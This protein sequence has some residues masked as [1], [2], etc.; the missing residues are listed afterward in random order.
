MSAK[1]KKG[2]SGSKAVRKLLDKK[3]TVSP[4][5]TTKVPPMGQTGRTEKQ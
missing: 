4:G 1:L 5:K 2:K 3:G